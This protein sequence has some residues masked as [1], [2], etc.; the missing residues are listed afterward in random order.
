MVTT[1]SRNSNNQFRSADLVLQWRTSSPQYSPSGPSTT[2]NNANPTTNP[3]RPT[4]EHLPISAESNHTTQRTQTVESISSNRRTSANRLIRTV[5]LD[6][7]GRQRNRCRLALFDV[8]FVRSQ[9]NFIVGWGHD[10]QARIAP[11]HY[12]ADQI[13]S[14]MKAKRLQRDRCQA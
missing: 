8:G 6:V 12:P 5:C 14:P 4:L 11:R 13:S 3:N 1:R 2:N 10:W 7:S 9:T